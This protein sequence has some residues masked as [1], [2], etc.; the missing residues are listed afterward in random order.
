[1]WRHQSDSPRAEVCTPGEKAPWI[2]GIGYG[3]EES[4]HFQ[5]AQRTRSS[6][7]GPSGKGTHM[8][9]WGRQGLTSWGSTMSTCPAPHCECGPL[10]CTH[11]RFLRSRRQTNSDGHIHMRENTHSERGKV[12]TKTTSELVTP[13]PFYSWSPRAH[14]LNNI[15]YSKQFSN[16]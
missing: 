11:C 4:L 9:A 13:K 12:L 2:P 1:M 16:R 6:S 3:G 10:L 14:F 15:F 7:A 5:L 8:K